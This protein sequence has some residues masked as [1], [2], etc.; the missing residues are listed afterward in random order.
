MSLRLTTE[1]EKRI[2]RARLQSCRNGRQPHSFSLR[3]QPLRDRQTSGAKAQ[4]K[5]E[6]FSA[7]LSPHRAESGAMGT[8]VKPCPD[9]LRRS[10]FRAE[11]LSLG[12]NQRGVALLAVL[13]LAVALSAMALATSYLV[14]T[15]VD[16]AS[17]QIEA[18]QSYFLAR[19]GIEASIDSIARS[20]FASPPARGGGPK[21]EFLPGQ[22]WLRYEF[23]G[24]SCIV[25]VV[26]ENAKL[27][28]NIAPAVQLAALFRA[29]GVSPAESAELGAAI[30]D[31]RSP[32]VSDAGSVFDAYYAGLPQPYKARHATLEDIEELLLVKGM[33]RELF[34][35]RLEER[36]AG[37][38]RRRPPLADLL[39]TEATGSAVNPNYALS[40]VLLA[41]PGWDEATA[42]SVIAIRET[43]PFQSVSELQAVAPFM[44]ATGGISSLT[45]AQGPVYTLTATCSLPDSPSRRSVRTL[46]EIASNQP[47][48]HQVLAWWDNW[49]FPHEAPQT[50]RNQA[51][52]EQ[53]G[54]MNSERENRGRL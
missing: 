46:V 8:P 30:V 16:A 31:W 24:G 2:V 10:S 27:N 19:G 1:D 3:L 20:T 53:A 15:E 54:T 42:S 35:G 41:L 44:A 21:P 33:S 39:T 45:V 12:G 26:P 29:L 5:L 13:W 32:R 48:Y 17:N 14:R 23:P 25:E 34:F 11:S 7:W 40:E 43:T 22:R 37:G 47:L 4:Q 28:L 38:W 49:P 36:S 52:G 50:L 51:A 18:Q 9:G 6:V